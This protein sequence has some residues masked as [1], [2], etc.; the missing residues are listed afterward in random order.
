[1]WRRRKLTHE[2]EPLPLPSNDDPGISSDQRRRIELTISCRDADTL[3]KVP[4]A[5]VVRTEHGVRVQVMHEGTRV[6]ADGYYGPW[7]TELIR[8]LRGHHEPQEELVVH[9]ILERLRGNAPV[10]IELGSFWAYYSIWAIRALAARAVLVE[11]D[12]SNL[13]VGQTNLRL[14]GVHAETL[15]AMLGGEHGTC[16]R[17]VCES[18]GVERTLP[19]VTI[20]GL[21]DDEGLARV[22][23][24]LMDVQGAE[25]DAL[26][27]AVG[28]LRE[29]VRFLVVSTHHHSIS[30]DPMTHQRCLG[31]LLDTGAHVIAEHTVGESFSG[32]GLI[33]VS[34]DASDRDLVVPVSR[35]RYRESLFG[36]LEPELA[37]AWRELGRL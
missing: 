37:R 2:A 22:D 26:E 20:P 31:L 10:V 15:Q 32:D 29:R 23:V 8:R 3:P 19:I 4:D 33:A 36:E 24:L 34:M 16:G 18:D 17:L 14:N 35:G 13:A 30:G 21:M 7:M 1:M 11:P 12:P 6:L 5:G 25:T 9:R 27:H 28:I